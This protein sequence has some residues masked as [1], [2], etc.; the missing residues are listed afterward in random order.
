MRPLKPDNLVHGQYAGYLQEP[1]VAKNSDVETYF[2]LRL[3]IDSWRWNGV[4]W[5]LRSGKCLAETAHEV[6]IELKP[7]PQDL[8]ADSATGRSNYLRFRLSPNSAVALAARVKRKR[9]G[10]RR[11]PAGALPGRGR[12][13]RGIAIRA[14][15]G[16]RD[17][18]RRSI[19]TREDAVE[20]AW[21]VVEPVLGN[22]HCVH[23]YGAAVGDRKRPTHS[24]QPTDAGS[25]PSTRSIPHD[26]TCPGGV[27]ARRR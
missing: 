7:P 11:R 17:G 27:S 21:A 9:K 4:P 13:W 5:Y 22:H 10:I 24:S 18:R 1:N 26:R 6:L 12:A 2:P 15:I 8:F 25:T 14:T 3:F 16:R 20:S 23:S 19:F